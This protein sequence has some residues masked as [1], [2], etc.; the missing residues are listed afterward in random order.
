[1]TNR[2]TIALDAMG[3]DHGST[4][5]VPAALAALS[6]HPELRLILVGDSAHLQGRLPK[7]FSQGISN[8]LE[9][10]HASEV[11]SM[12]ELPSVAL[13]S[14]KNSSMRVAINLVK[15]KRAQACVS[16]GNTGALMAI[17]RFVLKTLPEIDRPGILGIIPNRFGGVRV[18]DLG[19]NVDCSSEQLVQFALMGSRLIQQMN[20]GKL[21][22][23]GLLNVGREDIKGNEQVKATALLLQDL[24]DIQYI[25]FIEGNDLFNG[26]VDLVICD[27]FVGNIALKTA[28]GVASMIGGMIGDAFK[29]NLLT[30]LCGLVAYPVLRTV[31]KELDPASYNGASFIGLQG[32]VVKSHGGT[33]IRGFKRAIIE[34]VRQVQNILKA[35]KD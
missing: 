16:A 32:I 15:E 24:Q 8:R 11:V 14:K 13:R 25:G 2:I 10:Q 12:H 28:E 3:G 1:M 7:H 6:E 21:P 23:V 19:A 20:Q 5:V 35:K 4:V 34:A 33:N 22:R 26:S 30:R 9:I 31:R 27:G 17:A 29:K 18:V